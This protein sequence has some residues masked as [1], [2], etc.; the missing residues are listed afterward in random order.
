L[1]PKRELKKGA[2]S[3]P[4]LEKPTGPEMAQKSEVRTEQEKETSWVKTT[5][6]ERAELLEQ[7]KDVAWE[8]L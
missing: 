1:E 7:T 5:V 3:V 8:L 4:A 2:K 6:L